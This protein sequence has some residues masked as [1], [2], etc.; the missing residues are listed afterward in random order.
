[1]LAV[2]QSYSH[3]HMFVHF[4]KGDAWNHLGYLTTLNTL[5]ESQVNNGLFSV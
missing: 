5:I 2:T 4:I 1:M 3:A